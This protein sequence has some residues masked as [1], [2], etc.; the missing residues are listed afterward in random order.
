MWRRALS[1]DRQVWREQSL[2][3]PHSPQDDAQQQPAGKT[4][5][6]YALL[7]FAVAV[8]FSA[9]SLA[10]MS[11]MSDEG[12]DI[13][14][15]PPV[16]VAGDVTADVRP[17]PVSEILPEGVIIGRP[18]EPEPA[19]AL[20]PQ[21]VAAEANAFVPDMEPRDTAATAA[22]R[23]TIAD[24][25]DFAPLPS[26]P[27]AQPE[28]ENATA[29]TQA[30]P[31][32]FSALTGQ[33]GGNAFNSPVL[34]TARVTQFVNLR[35]RPSDDAEVLLVVPAD[36]E[37]QAATGCNWCEVVYDGKQGFIYKSFIRR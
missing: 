19:I 9:G 21:P 33:E 3:D 5:V 30:E 4:P 20:E 6:F 12:R 29:E 37:I 14:A 8:I 23:E 27:P 34:G 2:A 35:A 17:E 26:E 24:T 36:A 7:G 15:E 22:I 18:A 11:M 1:D 32:E 13:A 25:P 31:A 16:P 10:V 28:K